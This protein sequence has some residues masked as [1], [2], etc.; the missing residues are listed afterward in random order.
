MAGAR[1]R[2]HVRQDENTGVSFASKRN[3]EVV[4]RPFSA[5]AGNESKESPAGHTKRSDRWSEH[6]NDFT[7]VRTRTPESLFRKKKKP[8]HMIRLRISDGF[9]A[10]RKRF[11][12]FI[13]VFIAL[14]S[15]TIFF[16]LLRDI[17]ALPIKI[18]I[19]T[20]CIGFIEILITVVKR[21]MIKKMREI[22]ILVTDEGIE[23][24]GGSFRESLPFSDISRVLVI[25][26]PKGK[27]MM[28]RLTGTAVTMDIADYDDTDSLVTLLKTKIDP[29]LFTERKSSSWK[30]LLQTIGLTVGVVFFAIIVH[31]A[32]FDFPIDRIIQLLS[33]IFILFYKPISRSRGE[34]FRKL[35]LVIAIV[36]IVLSFL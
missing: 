8:H 33:G 1:E 29:T 14:S 35:E 18:L 30:V 2:F 36:I 4:P 26:D 9:F 34:R 28:V 3:H 24:V 21:I 5:T 7:C 19:F 13:Q 16:F 10:T 12:F 17:T 23:R 11:L 27:L 31:Q 20:S 32:G 15:S 6:V 22:E 25:T